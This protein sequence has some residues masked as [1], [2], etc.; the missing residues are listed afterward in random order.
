MLHG[1][2]APQLRS[3]QRWRRVRAAVVGAAQITP[4]RVRGPHVAVARRD[5]VL[6][7]GPGRLN[8]VRSVDELRER[9]RRVLVVGCWCRAAHSDARGGRTRLDN[10]PSF[11][12][13]RT[14][15]TEDSAG[16]LTFSGSLLPS[17][18]PETRS[19]QRKL[20]GPKTRPHTQGQRLRWAGRRR[21]ATCSLVQKC[22]H[23]PHAAPRAPD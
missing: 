16:H 5:A 23:S 10:V 6:D 20:G 3:N 21:A 12:V 1:A 9:P 15:C 7:D 17:R 2:R 13:C 18:S 8:V 19:F 4:R 11:R 14:R 22:A